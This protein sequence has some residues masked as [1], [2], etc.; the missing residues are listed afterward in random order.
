MCQAPTKAADLA[1][2][3]KYLWA[4]REVFRRDLFGSA[5]M[6]HVCGALFM[7]VHGD[8]FVNPRHDPACPAGGLFFWTTCQGGGD[9]GEKI[10]STE[11][12][13]MDLDG[14]NI[15]HDEVTTEMRTKLAVLVGPL[16]MATEMGTHAYALHYLLQ[17]EILVGEIPPPP[18][19]TGSTGTRRSGCASW[20]SRRP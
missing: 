1:V 17:G 15:R 20:R 11:E 19:L 7:F 10:A 16:K 8:R 5:D 3:S 12:T 4:G 9:M 14:I 2:L 6:L 13:T 18:W